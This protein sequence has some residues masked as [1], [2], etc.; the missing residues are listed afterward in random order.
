MNAASLYDLQSFRWLSSRSSTACVST[1]RHFGDIEWTGTNFSPAML[2]VP[3]KMD[4]SWDR[5]LDELRTQ[6][7]RQQILHTT[8]ARLRN[9]TEKGV[10]EERK[11]QD[12]NEE[13]QF[14]T[15]EELETTITAFSPSP[16][17]S[18]ASSPASEEAQTGSLE[19]TVERQH[20]PLSEKKPEL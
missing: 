3:S 14:L 4:C 9:Q 15:A 19:R 17:T 5:A 20:T 8:L 12:D 7:L 6:Q 1:R 11:K 13:E 2:P 16:P 10:S 18:L